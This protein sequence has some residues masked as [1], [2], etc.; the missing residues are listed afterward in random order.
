MTFVRAPLGLL[1]PVIG[2]LAVL[3]FSVLAVSAQEVDRPTY[4]IQV[5]G[6]AC[7]FC[8]YGLEKSLTKIS[9]IESIETDIDTG[10]VT[11]TM[12][13]EATLHRMA[14][15]QAVEDAG[16]ALNDF[17]EIRV[18]GQSLPSE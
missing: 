16:F 10:I 3:V 7:P 17:Q 11:I 12:A 5:D 4:T 14:A 8:A 9:G 18:V 13:A 2:A 1:T 15:T 6:M